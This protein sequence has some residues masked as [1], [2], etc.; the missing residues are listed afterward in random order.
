MCF[1][2]DPQGAFT[3]TPRKLP[4]EQQPKDS[5]N[6]IAPTTYPSS[7]EM[8]IV[9]QEFHKLH[10][11]KIDKLKDRYSAAANL[12]FQLWLKDMKVHMED[13]NLTEREAIQL[14]KDFTAEHTHDEVEF[15]WAWSWR[16]SRHLMALSTI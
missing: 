8:K 4:E 15:L 7:Y 11:P 13:W 16:I 2:V 3:S 1:A 6:Q 14:V 12:V 10:E 5:I 9:A